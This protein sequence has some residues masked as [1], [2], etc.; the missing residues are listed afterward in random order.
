MGE[1]YP[2]VYEDL[3]KIGEVRIQKTNQDDQI[4]LPEGLNIE[5]AEQEAFFDIGSL[6]R[7]VAP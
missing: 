5:P 7:D 4:E 1:T 2:T 6:G 3:L